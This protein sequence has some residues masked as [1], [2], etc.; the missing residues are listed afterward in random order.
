MLPV[1]ENKVNTTVNRRK[2]SVAK[3]A[4]LLSR[5]DSVKLLDSLDAKSKS[6]KSLLFWRGYRTIYKF[7]YHVVY[8]IALYLS[9]LGVDDNT[10]NALP[11]RTCYQF[12]EVYGGD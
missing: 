10:R 8:L 12:K 1:R 6:Q 3:L 11:C 7:S 4:I 5:G 2:K 9:Y